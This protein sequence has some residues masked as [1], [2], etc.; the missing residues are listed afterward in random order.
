MFLVFYLE[1]SNDV[2]GNVLRYSE[3]YANYYLRVF[4]SEVKLRVSKFRTIACNNNNNNDD[5]DDDDDGH[6]DN[7][8]NIYYLS[9]SL[10]PSLLRS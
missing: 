10:V 2:D 7:N 1:K 8:N 3:K 6:D 9:S 4:H 5:D